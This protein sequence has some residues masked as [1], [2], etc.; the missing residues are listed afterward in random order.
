MGTTN[1]GALLEQGDG[2]QARGGDWR[3]VDDAKREARWPRRARSR[4]SRTTR[5][6]PIHFELSV[7]AMKK[8]LTYEGRADQHAPWAVRP[9]S[10]VHGTAAARR[11]SHERP[12]TRLMLALHHPPPDAGGAGHGGDV[13]AGLR[14]HLRDRRSGRDDDQ[15]RRQPAGAR[16]RARHARP[17]PAD[18]AAI[19]GVRERRDPRQFRQELPGRPACHG[20]DLRAHAGDHGTGR[21]LA[22]PVA[23]HRPADGRLC[24]A[25]AARAGQ[26]GDHDRL[27]PGL[28]AAQFL[29]RADADHG[30]RRDAARPD[31]G[32]AAPAGLGPR[33]DGQSPGRAG[34][35]PHRRRAPAPASCRR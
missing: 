17:R 31:P 8:G 29:G 10:E 21:R 2:R 5:M 25:A 22:D 24:R 18:V 33:H 20:T 34:L 4:S 32:V 27:D 3:T 15:P 19:P 35:L 30:L 16:R 14:R 6:L 23:R 13:G 11:S 7:W 26:Q 1:L 28:L 9:S 12:G